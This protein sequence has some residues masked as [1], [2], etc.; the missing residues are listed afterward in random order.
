MV[1][2][3]RSFRNWSRNASR[4]CFWDCYWG[5]ACQLLANFFPVSSNTPRSLCESQLGPVFFPFLKKHFNV[6]N[7]IWGVFTWGHLIQTK[8]LSILVS[9]YFHEVLQHLKTFIYSKFRFQRVL[10]FAIKDAWIS[11]LLQDEAF[12]WRLGKLLCGLKSSLFLRFCYL[13]ISCLEI[14]ITVN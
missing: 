9:F 10:C 5:C 3:I 6:G 7:T 2:T 1:T 14:N 13:N 12:S 4:S 11:R 8:K